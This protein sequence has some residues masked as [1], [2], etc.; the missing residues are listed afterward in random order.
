MF[1]EIEL[2]DHPRKSTCDEGMVG[3]G[4]CAGV[5]AQETRDHGPEMVAAVGRWGIL[6]GVRNRGAVNIIYKLPQSEPPY[7]L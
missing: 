6:R 4:P 1:E 3:D 2:P 7:V 5:T